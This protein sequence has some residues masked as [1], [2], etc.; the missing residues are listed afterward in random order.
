MG[1]RFLQA[2]RGVSISSMCTV[3]TESEAISFI[4]EGYEEDEI[5]RGLHESISQGIFRMTKR[6]RLEEEITLSGG[7]AKN[8][9]IAEVVKAL[10]RKRI[11]MPTE[12]RIVG[13]LGAAL[14]AGD[15][16]LGN[17]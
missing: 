1:S 15:M 14:Y 6:L 10:F 7:V 2:K 13:P 16:A 17:G 9:G 4:A 8:Q 11:N 12:P 5:I 3:F